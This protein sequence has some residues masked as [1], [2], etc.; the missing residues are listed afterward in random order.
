MKHLQTFESFLNEAKVA[1]IVVP[2]NDA[3]D[4]EE[5]RSYI[6]ETLKKAGVDA[7]CESSI[8]EIEV[9]LKNKRD[10]SKAKKALDK[11]G[12]EFNT[13]ESF[14]DEAKKFNFDSTDIR[15]AMVTGLA[16]LLGM[17]MLDLSDA[18]END[19]ATRSALDQCSYKMSK[20]L[21]NAI[22]EFTNEEYVNEAVKFNPKPFNQVK[23]GDT[24]YVMGSSNPWK[25]LAVG[26]GKEFDSKLKKHDASGVIAD[27]K[28]RPDNF[29]L[30]KGDFEELELIAVQNG[31]E[32][33]VYTYDDG[34]AWVNK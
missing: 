33:A 22:D 24:A 28:S 34:G 1:D 13:N 12:L 30:E 11:I 15:D 3:Y 17:K 18:I 26:T 7:G 25:V 23:A 16:E 9:Y 20:T 8:G 31:K 21:G 6:E 2:A 19:S 32:I 10:L 14:L 4:M 27:M 5:E 29:G